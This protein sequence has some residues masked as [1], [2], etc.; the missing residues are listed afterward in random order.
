MKHTLPV[1]FYGATYRNFDLALY[2]S[3]RQQ[4]YGQDIGQNGWLTVEELRQFLEWLQVRPGMALLDIGS[5]SGGPALFIAQNYR[6]T[7][8]GVE[9]NRQAVLRANKRARSL[10]LEA[11]ARFAQVD[12]HQP[13][14]FEEH[15]FHA[16][17]CIDAIR[18]LHHRLDLF[19]EWWRVLKKGGRM[20]F[21]EQIVTGLISSEEFL[22]RSFIGYFV[23][24]PPAMNEHMIREAGFELLHQADVTEN[25]ILISRRWHAARSRQRRALQQ[26]EGRAFFEGV[27][28]FLA[29][30]HRLA[31]ERRLS[32]YV[33]LA[34]KSRE[35]ANDSQDSM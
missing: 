7:V 4:T 30:A 21:T 11:V 1:D 16:I 26:I 15:T 22:L 29:A 18:A 32:R 23:V 10:H 9:I 35:K 14:P 24:A 33:F 20:L 28:Q 34:Q 2:Q 12:A 27:Q 17:L 25:L 31:S 13:L 8:V 6:A 5:G 19:R 3:I